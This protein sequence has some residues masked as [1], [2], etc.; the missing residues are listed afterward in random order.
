M[1]WD[2]VP[3]SRT[4]PVGCLGRF[5]LIAITTLRWATVRRTTTV[6][7]ARLIGQSFTAPSALR[8]TGTQADR[9]VD[10]AAPFEAPAVAVVPHGGTLTADALVGRVRAPRPAPNAA[11]HRWAGIA[12]DHGPG[13]SA[14]VPRSEGIAAVQ[15]PPWRL[16]AITARGAASLLK[17]AA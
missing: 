15:Y 4:P 11:G 10:A 13:S 2:R 3:V 12:V 7:R 6:R 16:A 14:S 17:A 5:P 9:P 8:R 1:R